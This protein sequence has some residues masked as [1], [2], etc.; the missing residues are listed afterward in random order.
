[1][2]I[3]GVAVDRPIATA[4][5]FLIIVVV[6]IMGF[7]FLP[8]DLLPPIEWPQLTVRTNYPN[9]GPEE[10][11]RI[12]TD[13]VE[14]ALAGVPNVES[15]RSV[16]EE[17]MSR[18]TLEFA[19]G[20]NIDEAANDVRAA[21][22]R[23]RDDLPPEVE[24]PRLWKFDPDNFPVAIIGARSPLGMEE[25]TRILERE[26]A[27]RF[28]QIPG[29]G[30]V[31]VWGGV[32]REV[33]VQILRDR[34]ASSRLSALDVQRALA[35]ENVTLP[36]GDMREGTRDL[37]VR[38][39]GEYR[40]L[41][42][43]AAT[44]ITVVDGRPIRVGDVARV[45]DGVEDVN[46][47][48]QVDGL[49]MVRM[50]VRK[51][52]GANTVEVAREAQRVMERINAERD[53]IELMLIV[54]QS[55]FIKDS[56]A[57]VQQS[58]VWGGLLAVFILYLFLRNGSSTFIIALSIPISLIATFGLLYFNRFTLNQMS[59]GGLALGIGLIVDNAIV[60]LDNVVRL[61]EGGRSL[62]ESALTGTSQ[63][64][65]AIV[66]STLTTLVIFLP[67]AF[68]HTVSGMLFQ[69]LA[70]VVVF[71]LLCSLLVALTLVP[72]LAARYLSVRPDGAGA[73]GPLAGFG[74]WFRRLEDGYADL[75]ARLLRRRPL[76]FLTTGLLLAGAVLLWPRIPVEL[77]PQT[78]ADE[79]SLSLEMAQGTNIAVVN[80]SLH[81][82]E[83]LVRAAAPMDDVKHVS[84]EIRNGDAEVEL[85]LRG[86][87]QRDTDSF[88]LA[89]R[90]RRETA[91]LIPGAEIRV[92][93][94][95]GLWM[96]RRLFGSGG[97]AAVQIELRGYDLDLAD[98]VAQ[99]LKTVMEGVPQIRDVNVSRRE[100]RPEQNMVIDREK[101]AR[102]GL[103]VSEIAGTI[104]A[105]VGGVR[106]GVFREGGDE[107]P[108]VVRLQ[109][110][111]RLTSLDLG[112]VSVS[113]PD[114]G[115]LPVSAVVHAERRRS[116][117]TIERVDG[118]RV[119]YITANLDAGAALG[120]VIED[121]R[122]RLRDFPLP[123]DFSL[124]FGGE[125]EEQQKASRD[126]TLSILMAVVLIYMVMAAQFERFLDPVIVMTSVPLALIGV[127]PTLL[128]TGTTLNV[129]S[130]MGIVMLIGI[131]VNNAIVLVDY[132]NLKRREE[133]L[134]VERAVIE[135]ARLRLRPILMTT[136][137][138]VLGMLPLA[139]GAGAGAEIQ[140]ALA[141]AV[142]GG[143]TVSTLITLVVIPAAYTGVHG[144]RER[145]RGPA[146]SANS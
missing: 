101:I 34:L 24:S 93:A 136:A 104:Q 103:S 137:T 20:T 143:M 17:G 29:A 3:T 95:S 19:Q 100:G 65:G 105:N 109:P 14:N 91:G 67:V 13:R 11:E 56:I 68:M 83:R 124:L 108:I 64:G 141:R 119:T 127:V 36:G 114:G 76:I 28:E 2:R 44:V 16:S 48:V 97:D 112:A 84:V 52:S 121:L 66:A 37:Y 60:V 38:T 39:Q 73:G 128:L 4:M 21:L 12:V 86:A 71:A 142:V 40:S 7:R 23:I 94:Q 133:G 54:D 111:D 110:E 129:Q 125:Y 135:S 8:V 75:L 5:V 6:G 22:D 117:T 61:R 78:D 57:S 99:D 118:Q 113:T 27:Q 31:D 145:R 85:A 126:F 51:Q 72:M 74:R 46:R 25:M 49:P 89:E 106:A 79:I 43:I 15:M 69:E 53:D 35:R 115:V 70:L 62:R 33:Q 41:E 32:Y 55:A 88:E 123:A 144:W 130:L 120:D 132:V 82:L 47:L 81:E 92:R 90:L 107:F 122:A 131:V 45:V 10:I 80:E 139:I 140:A 87:G 42:E 102:L 58:A 63:V 116:P 138:T 26:I 1:M 77:A 98:R 18:V 50:G 96:L 30:S 134:P 9:V 59:F 146:A